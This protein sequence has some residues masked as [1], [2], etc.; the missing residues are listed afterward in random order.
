ML[1]APLGSAEPSA[2]LPLPGA[3]YLVAGTCDLGVEWAVLDQD[4][5]SR[6]V[7]AV[8]ADSRALVGSQDL[9]V[10]ETSSRVPL[11]L[12]CG[13]G[14]WL[15]SHAFDPELRSGFMESSDLNRARQAWASIE[16]GAVDST[17][18]QRETDVTPEYLGWIREG[19]TQ[20]RE[21]LLRSLPADNVAARRARVR[22]PWSSSQRHP[23]RWAALAA[24]LLVVVSALA[25]WLQ[26][27]R[28]RLQEENLELRQRPAEP[29]VNL[30]T[31]RLFR[32]RGGQK[33]TIPAEAQALLLLIEAPSPE[34]SYRLEIRTDDLHQVI[35][36][37]EGVRLIGAAEH[38]TVAL[39][40][41]FLP[42]GKYRVLVSAAGDGSMQQMEEFRI[43][44]ESQ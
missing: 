8:P 5:E 29:A 16:Q 33:I 43:E 23:K 24:A 6:R 21:V 20:A 27:E 1:R 12:R 40:A 44:I 41:R 3:V 13:L 9:R 30:A 4:P 36:S 42:A 32:V 34:T 38:L 18:A 39:P 31:A 7:Y 2:P 37:Q 19:P 26:V 17:A 25:G 15:P 22:S 11:N 10:S 35:W 28:S 14:L